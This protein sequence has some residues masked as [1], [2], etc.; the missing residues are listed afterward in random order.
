[1]QS[2]IH[3]V[4]GKIIPGFEY[5]LCWSVKP[6][7]GS[8]FKRSEPCMSNQNVLFQFF[9]TI[10]KDAFVVRMY[11]NL[12]NG[13]FIILRSYILK[14]VNAGLTFTK[15]SSLITT[16]K[17]HVKRYYNIWVITHSTH[18]RIHPFTTRGNTDQIC[19]IW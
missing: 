8:I 16:N 13:L 5:R 19:F 12:K 9:D 18:S 17:W 3:R 6:F 2:S 7:I 15:F 11:T 1:L 4:T 14:F 10:H